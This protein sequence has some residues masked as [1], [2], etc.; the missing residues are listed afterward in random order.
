MESAVGIP[1]H[2]MDRIENII[3]TVEDV[4][5]RFAS[6]LSGTEKGLLDEVLN[7]VK[8]LSITNGRINSSVENL[9][10]LSKIKS[11]LKKAILNKEYLGGVKEL[12]KGIDKILAAQ[13]NYFNKDFKVS[14]DFKAKT[15]L[16]RNLAVENTVEMLAGT[17]IEA[18]VT[19][20]INDMLLR[21]ITSGGKYADLVK[22]MSDFLTTNEN[23]EGA[24]TR[25]AQTWTNTSLNQF[26]G[27][28]N[29]LMTDDLG[30]EWYMYVGSNKD[31]SREFCE[32]L[33]KKKYVHK[34]EIPTIVTGKID[35]HQ[36]EI[37]EKTKLPKGMIAGTNAD[38][39]MVN[40]GGWNC[41]HKLVPVSEVA[42]PKEVREKLV[43]PQKENVVGKKG[44]EPLAM[45]DVAL[46]DPLQVNSLLKVVD[47][48]REKVAPQIRKKAFK[49]MLKYEEYSKH[50]DTYIMKGAEYN[51]R[52]FQ[53]AQKLSKIKDGYI[54]VFPSK[55]QLKE[56]KELEKSKDAFINDVYLF[57]KKTYVLKKADL[58]EVSG[59]SKEAIKNHVISGS[60][61]AGFVVME[62]GNTVNRWNFIKGIRLGW[63]SNTKGVIAN[64][65]GQ[66]Y[67]IDKIKAFDDIWFQ[68]NIK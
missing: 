58:K 2:P 23:G 3:N 20:K 25:Y 11:K 61:Q 68:R 60:V 65:R 45:R 41:G 44:F 16:V 49:N 64:W 47:K 57:D 7:L 15:D 40:C 39:F 4:A 37:Y 5:E 27:Q 42:V 56:I 10:L 36:C 19:N 53:T 55:G 31:T 30:L 32:L 46:F 34:S 63:G 18:N 50:G 33:V 35:G 67:E 28:N 38:N 14:K 26:A 9:K 52:E 29:K 43:Y 13:V 48:F 66:W 6:R 12:V 54:V 24:L 1:P 62:L 17:G 8:D 51:D 22:D 21:S 59:G